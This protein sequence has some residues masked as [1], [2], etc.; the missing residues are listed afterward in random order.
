VPEWQRLAVHVVGQHREV[1]AHLLDWVRVVV[2][3]G[4][5]T[6]AEG[7]EDHPLGFRQGFDEVHQGSHRHAAPFGDARPA[8]DAEVLCDLLVVLQHSQPG[9][10]QFDGVLD[11]AVDP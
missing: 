6:V 8:L 10:A 3:A 5:R 1:V 2:D 11:Q 4:V 7:V 9:Q